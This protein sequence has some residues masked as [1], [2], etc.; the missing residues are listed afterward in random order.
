MGQEHAGTVEAVGTNK[1]AGRE[2]IND[3]KLNLVVTSDT[4]E[5]SVEKDDLTQDLPTTAVTQTPTGSIFKGFLGDSFV[6]YWWKA[7]TACCIMLTSLMAIILILALHQNRPLPNWPFTITLN[8]P[9]SI[10]VVI[11]KSSMLAVVASGMRAVP[12]PHQESLCL[13]YIC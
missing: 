13:H 2:D 4:V 7:I 12:F 5:S 6:A 10:M 3:S 8:S 11:L 9:I 1:P